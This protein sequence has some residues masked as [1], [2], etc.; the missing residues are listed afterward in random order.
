MNKNQKSIRRIAAK[1][2]G[3]TYKVHREYDKTTSSGKPSVTS[4]SKRS[5]PAGFQARV[6]KAP[7]V[8]ASAGLISKKVSSGSFGE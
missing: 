1:N 4:F 5:I 8:A 7:K 3:E 2:N 6:S